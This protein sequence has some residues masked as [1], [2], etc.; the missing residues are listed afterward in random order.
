MKKIVLLAAVCLGLIAPQVKAAEAADIFN[1]TKTWAIGMAN[2]EWKP[3]YCSAFKPN[4]G[5]MT[6]LTKTYHVHKK[7]IG[8]FLK[9][10]I[11]ASWFDVTYVNYK[12][13]PDWGAFDNNPAYA[14]GTRFSWSDTSGD[15]DGDVLADPNLGSHQI[16]VAMG[17]GLSATFAPFFYSDSNN[18]AK[19]KAKLYC[20][21]L[22]TFSMMLISEPNDTR[23]NYAFVPYISFGGMISWKVLSIFVEGRWGSA[24][25][26]IGSINDDEGNYDD[27]DVNLGDVINFDKM[28]CKN[29]GIRFGI[30][31]N[32]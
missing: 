25:Y 6:S 31:L 26:K 29:Y 4:Y 3:E 17:I 20:R 14:P 2:S 30:G 18:L 24:N 19:L 21:F 7:P 28:S 15:G 16:D 5:F 10:G 13:A 1:R 12:A 32:F 23:F 8:G 9:F 22:P 27:G 11:D